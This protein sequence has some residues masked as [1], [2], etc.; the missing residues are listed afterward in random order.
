MAQLEGDI[1]VL[2]AG[3]KMGPSLVRLARRASDEAG[4]TRRIIAVSRFKTPTLQAQLARNGIDV[5]AGDLLDPQFV[6]DLP[7]VRNVISMVGHKFGTAVDPATTWA[8]NAFVPGIVMRRFP[9]SNVVV[10]STGHV[11]SLVAVEGPGSRESDSPGPVGEYA[12]SALAR[13]RIVEFFAAAQRTP[14]AILR[15]NY[16]V[17]LR[18]GVLRDLADQLM[19]GEPISLAMGYVNLIWQR[20]ANAMVLGSLGACRIPPLVLNVTGSERLAVRDLARR[21]GDRL[22]VQPLFTGSEGETALLSDASL[23]RELFGSPAVE[24]KT[25]I[26]WVADWVRRGGRS[27]DRPTHFDERSGRF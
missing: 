12:Q 3:G 8:V 10:L 1:I 4:V 5:I 27:L 19:K 6:A 23:A 16:A 17:E 14:T 21:L 20:D 2:G 24:V 26:D 11:Y 9:T 15:L 25:V 22:G 7:D 18:Y 13:E